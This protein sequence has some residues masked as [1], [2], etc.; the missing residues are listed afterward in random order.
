MRT[1]ARQINPLFRGWIGYYGRFSRSA[2]FPLVDYVNQKL[3]AW[4][5]RKCKRFRLHKTLASLFL[6][7]LA[8][9]NAEL[10]VHWR[11]FGTTT[12]A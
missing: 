10:F 11:F 12:F 4:I 5:M 9:D 6:R 2:L 1:T 3:R 7:K 8:R